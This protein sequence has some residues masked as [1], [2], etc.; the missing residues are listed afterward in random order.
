MPARRRTVE[1]DLG[2]RWSAEA[3]LVAASDERLLAD[4]AAAVLTAWVA[5]RQDSSAAPESAED[6]SYELQLAGYAVM[7]A[8]RRHVRAESA[9]GVSGLAGASA[10][11]AS[12]VVLSGGVIRHAS[13]TE[14][15]ELVTRVLDD[16][17][18]ARGVLLDADVRCDTHYVLAAAGLLA[19]D[20]PSAAGGLVGSGGLLG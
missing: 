5:Q 12:T 10:R 13:K 11:T 1:G 16:R 6:R 17:G 2:L 15:A 9:Y 20:H 14:R 3:L 8:L 18:G 19:H 7:V 4:E